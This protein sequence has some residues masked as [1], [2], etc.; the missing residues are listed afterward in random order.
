MSSLQRYTD[1]RK[2]FGQIGMRV[3]IWNESPNQE[4]NIALVIFGVLDAI[5]ESAI[6]LRSYED[7]EWSGFCKGG[8]LAIYGFL[9]ALYVQQDAVTALGRVLEIEYRPRHS[10][11]KLLRDGRNHAIGHP[12]PNLSSNKKHHRTLGRFIS[13]GDTNKNS[14]VYVSE[15]R[16]EIHMIGAARGQFVYLVSEVRR[17]SGQIVQK[18][19]ELF[20]GK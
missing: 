6:A 8:L 17:I 13:W 20:C 14:L 1:W 19:A 4:K 11:L 3:P 15:N 7:F 10:D 5:D 9:Q 18:H 12:A 16:K 2:K